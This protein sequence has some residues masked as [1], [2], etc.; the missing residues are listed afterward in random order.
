M[1][2]VITWLLWI[3]MTYDYS[4]SHLVIHY[5]FIHNIHNLRNNNNNNNNNQIIHFYHM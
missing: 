2:I 4:H 5:S 1:A 3:I